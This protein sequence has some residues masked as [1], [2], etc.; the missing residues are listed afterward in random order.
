MP[1]FYQASFKWF[2]ETPGG[3]LASYLVCCLQEVNM[4]Y[5]GAFV[6]VHLYETKLLFLVLMLSNTSRR[7][8]QLYLWWA[9]EIPGNTHCNYE[10]F[11]ANYL[12]GTMTF[13]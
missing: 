4:V 12:N 2:V 13:R 10:E 8:D 11:E 9:L 3:V 7:P 1:C 5:R 6:I